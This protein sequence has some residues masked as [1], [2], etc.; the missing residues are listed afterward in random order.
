M[1][2]ARDILNKDRNIRLLGADAF[3]LGGYTQVPNAILASKRL[4]DSAKMAYA[5]LLSYAWQDDFCFPGQVAMA[6][7]WGKSERSV[8]TALKD[9]EEAGYLKIIRQGLG[10]PN[11]YELTLSVDDGKIRDKRLTS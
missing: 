8:R 7:R 3:T 10:K 11:I 1:D 4:S 6:E 5:L 2:T 9:L